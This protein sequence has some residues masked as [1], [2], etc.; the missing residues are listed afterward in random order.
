MK[1]KL[2]FLNEENENN[3]I[4]IC[5]RLITYEINS[6]QFK[7]SSWYNMIESPKRGVLQLMGCYKER[8]LRPSVAAIFSK[9]CLTSP[10]D[11]GG[12]GS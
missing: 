11:G 7:M 4:N 9:T 3:C 12:G 1:I 10:G 8:Y 6:I 5:T 2:W